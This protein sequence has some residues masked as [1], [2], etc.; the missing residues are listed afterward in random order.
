MPSFSSYFDFCVFS[1]GEQIFPQQSWPITYEVICC[2]VISIRQVGIRPYS[3]AAAAVADPPQTQ[4]RVSQDKAE[5]C[6]YHYSPKVLLNG[7]VFK[8]LSYWEDVVVNFPPSG[9]IEL[10]FHKPWCCICA[11]NVRSELPGWTKNRNLSFIVLKGR[12]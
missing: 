11:I 7:N 2:Q 6:T 9:E 12:Q 8:Q 4:L 10:A 3:Q 1:E 5:F